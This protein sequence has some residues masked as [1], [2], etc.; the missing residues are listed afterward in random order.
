MLIGLTCRTSYTTSNN[1]VDCCIYCLQ[2]VWNVTLTIKNAR[3]VEDLDSHKVE[4]MAENEFGITVHG[5]DIS[6]EADGV[7]FV[8]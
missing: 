7:I 8:H 4:F 1:C 5:V 2:Y 6:A 3:K